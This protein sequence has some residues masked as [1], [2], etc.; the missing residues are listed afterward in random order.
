M[1]DAARK[2]FEERGF[3]EVC[4][5]DIA[6][7]VLVSRRTFVNYFESTAVRVASPAPARPW[8]TPWRRRPPSQLSPGAHHRGTSSRRRRLGRRLRPQ[9]LRR[10]CAAAKAGPSTCVSSR[11]LFYIIHLIICLAMVARDQSICIGMT[12]ACPYCRDVRLRFA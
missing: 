10:S 9:E 7:E 11:W 1:Q 5:E 8:L 6:T 12:S 4:V 2:L 3:D